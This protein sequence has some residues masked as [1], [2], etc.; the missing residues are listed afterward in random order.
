[1]SMQHLHCNALRVFTC[2]SLA[3]ALCGCGKTEPQRYAIKGTVKL[4]GQPINNATLILT[5]TGEG[6]A[7]AATIQHGSFEL[8]AEV[9]PSAGSFSVRINP[10]EAEVEEVSIHRQPPKVNVRPRIPTIYQRE[11][12]LHAV[13]TGE[14]NQ[15]LDFDLKSP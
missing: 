6:L 9:G 15:S 3:I 4:N 13:V 11:G 8:P 2:I 1:M 14:S 10:N 12:T 7:A 5:P